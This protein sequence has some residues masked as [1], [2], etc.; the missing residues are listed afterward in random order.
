MLR[1]VKDKNYWVIRNGRQ[2]YRTKYR[3]KKEADRKLRIIKDWFSR[4]Y[5]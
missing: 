1:V 4:N 5:T 2:L 3:S